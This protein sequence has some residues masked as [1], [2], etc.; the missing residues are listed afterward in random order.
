MISR[1]RDGVVPD[2]ELDP[3]LAAEFE[4]LAERVGE[5][6]DRAEVTTALELIWQRVRRCNRYVEERAPWQLA[7]DPA[8]CRRARRDARVAG[9]GAARADRDAARLHAGQ[10]ATGC[11]TRWRRPTSRIAGAASPRPA[12]GEPSSALEPLFPKRA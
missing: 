11:S 10:H 9:R 4:G 1:Y 6:L 8:R 7:R 3:E 12:A 5:L 2:V